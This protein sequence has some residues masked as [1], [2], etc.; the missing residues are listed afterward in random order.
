MMQQYL[1]TKKEY[2][3]CIL[4]YRIGDFYEMFFDDAKI[5]SEELDLVLTG[6]DCG[7]EER[8]PM[9]G[10]PFHASDNYIARLVRKG[11]KVAIGEQVEDPKLAKGLVKRS[12]IRVVTPGTLTENEALDDS[13]NN[14]LMCVSYVLE[15][16]G[17]SAIDVS[18][19]DYYV[20]QV[21]ELKE[22]YDEINRFMPSELICDAAFLLSGADIAMI[23]DRWG[24]TPS[25]VPARYFDEGRCQELL[26]EHF[27]ANAAGLGLSDMFAGILAAGGVLRYVYDTQ[28]SSVEYITS[29]H[30]YSTSEYMVIDTATMRNLEL[31]ES[32]R[33]KDKKGTLLWVLDKTK[34]AM[35]S[36]FLR[37]VISQPL[38]KKA[39]IEERQEAISDLNERF[40]DREEIMEYLRPVYDLERLLAKF[41]TRRANA[42]DLLAFRQSISM[43]PAIKN[44]VSGF[45]AGLLQRLG[46]ELD[47]LTDLCS[48]LEMSIDPEAPV[49]IRDG[50]MILTGYNEDVDRLRASK[51][52]GRKWLL[53]LENEEREKTGIRTLK[54]KYNKNFG[55]CIEVTN[56]FKSQVPD[57][58]LR[59]QTLTTG[60]RYTTERLEE[61]SSEILG[62][63]EKLKSLEYE[64]FLEIEDR[65]AGEAQ[66]IQQSAK[67]IAYLDVLCSLSNVATRN[68]YVCPK[69]N[70]QG[71]I[72]IRDGRHPVVELMLKD[73]SFIAN[74]TLLNNGADR[75][76]IITGPNM[77]G[78]STYMRQ[79]ALITLMAQ[80]GSFVPARS[81]DI[82]I[83]DRIFTRVG[84]SDDLASGQST[85]MV[86]MT[87]V[88]NI[89]RNATSKSL[90]ILDEIGRGTSTYDGLSIA[91]SVVEYISDKK[92]LGAKALFATHYHELTELEGKIR[93]VHNYCIAVKEN[94]DDLIFLRKIVPG[95]ADKS[96]GIAVAKLA[97]VPAEVTDRANEIAEQLSMS[98]I[99]NA[100]ARIDTPADS[101]QET[102]P[103]VERSGGLQQTLAFGAEPLSQVAEEGGSRYGSGSGAT[104][105]H[106]P[107]T[108]EQ[109]NAQKAAADKIRETDMTHLTPME[110]FF[111]L[112]E[113]QEQLKLK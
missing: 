51:T 94:A 15:A 93:G 12:V 104:G 71:R 41:S 90:L 11:Y 33:E 100:A 110:A 13:R 5:A 82:A 21:T 38:L 70:E 10:I 83:C 77:A 74:D 14:Y 19:G 97:G 61:L 88:A 78:K 45:D 106:V 63:D 54:V 52:E 46:S 48:L 86:E 111:L 26:E 22:L 3:D 8:A 89:L 91:W 40:I 31:L 25:E 59:K 95:G 105:I 102:E 2:P 17:I 87:E 108:S 66:R 20:T 76:A 44:L 73:G 7:M 62:A 53:D 112:N 92:K 28:F 98:D 16:F 27:H 32:M 69:I 68:R 39:Q 101:R 49:S 47:P 30:P 85:F 79:V 84:A 65:V 37:T 57:Y 23:R 96:Y 42:L 99:A 36:R 55:Y 81:A 103:S 75:I 6:K 9:C 113:L 1:E 67:A 72:D 60:E 29:I 109:Y 43:L 80:I 58:F 18:T 35:G 107:I 56:T 24:V 34:T 4:F 50:G 64:L